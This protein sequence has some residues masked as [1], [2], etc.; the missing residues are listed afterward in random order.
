MR[1]GHL[2]GGVVLHSGHEAG[3]CLG[4]CHPSQD[5]SGPDCG[6]IEELRHHIEGVLVVCNAEARQ[7][8]GNSVD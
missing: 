2:A 5:T 3:L 6:R 4:L 7:G 1:G 8:I